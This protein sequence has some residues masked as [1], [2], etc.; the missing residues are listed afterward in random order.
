MPG[1]VRFPEVRKLLEAWNEMPAS[2]NAVTLTNGMK[3][4]FFPWVSASLKGSDMTAQGNALGTK[5]PS[6]KSPDRAT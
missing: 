1:E 3:I 2:R 6:R 5:R 4:S